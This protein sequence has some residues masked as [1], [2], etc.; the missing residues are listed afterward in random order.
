MDHG[1]QLTVM[2]QETYDIAIQERYNTA[3]MAE[4]EI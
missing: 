4:T 1:S 2:E 3:N